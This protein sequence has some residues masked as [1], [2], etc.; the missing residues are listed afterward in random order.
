MPVFSL[1]TLLALPAGVGIEEEVEAWEPRARALLDGPA[2]CIEVQGQA[3]VALAVVQQGGWRGPGKTERHILSGPFTGTLDKGMWRDLK[4]TLS[5]AP[6]VSPAV[7]MTDLMP[8][9]GRKAGEHKKGEVNLSLSTSDNGESFDISSAGAQ[10]INLVDGVLE[11]IRPD[12]T[13]SWMEAGPAE[14]VVL[15]QR[16]PVK[17]A[18]DDEQIELRTTFPGRGAPTR[19]DVTLPRAIKVGEGLIKARIYDGQVHIAA[20]PTPMGPLPTE[21]RA[22]VVAGVLG[23]TVGIDQQLVYTAYRPCGG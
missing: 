7:R 4:T 1:I 16:A 13:L 8:V 6:G 23:F 22:S 15:V 3:T 14:G 10:G 20:A 17:G 21:E 2:A 11:G 18:D 5:T 19:L 12:V 9:T